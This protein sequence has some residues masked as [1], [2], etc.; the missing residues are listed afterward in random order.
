[1]KIFVSSTTKD[2]ADARKKVCEQIAGLDN[3]YVCMDCY[4]ASG[5]P[6]AE[7]DDSKVKECDAFVI[8]VAHYYGSCPP[9][10]ERSFTELEY[11]AAVASDKP[12]YA[13]LASE[14]FPRHLRENDATYATLEAF[15]QKLGEKHLPKY[16]DNPDQ[17]CAHVAAAVPRP[18]EQAGRITVPKLPQPYLA[19]PYPIQENFTGRVKERTML[20]DWVSGAD[21]RPMLSLVGMGGLGKSALTWF[22]LH[23]DLPQEKLTFSGIIWWSFYE[24]EASFESFLAHALLYASG[25]TIDPGQVPSDY[26][27]LSSLWCILRDS[28]FL[29][30]FDGAERLLRAYHALDAAYKGDDF[31]EQAGDKHLL[32]ADPRA[33]Q[34]L[35]WLATPGVKTRTLLTTRLHPR[36]LEALAGCRKKDLEHL[37]P[38][39]AVEF[40]RRQGIKGPRHAIVGACEP[41]DFLPLCI[42][43]L[44]GAIREDPERPG[45]IGVAEDWHPPANLKD[46]QRQHHILELSYDTMAKDRR[47]LLSRIAAMRGPV[48]YV[49]ATV[50]STYDDEDDLKAALLELVA[51]GLLFRREGQ[52]R[53]DLHPIV[54]QYAY[55]RLGDKAATHETLKDYFGT[56]PKP[57]KIETLDDLQPVIELFHHTI[58]AGGFEEALTIYQDRLEDALYFQ[59]GAYDVDISL[60]EAFFPEGT[61]KPPRLE[62][63][64]D[65]AWLLNAL[66]IACDKTGQSRKAAGLLERSNAI[67]ENR[68]NTAH[69]ARGLGNLV[70]SQMLL[71]ELEAAG[72]NLRRR[73]EID[74]KMDEKFDEAIGHQ[75]LGRLLTYTAA[76]DRADKE[77]ETALSMFAKQQ[78]EQCQGVVW[79]YRALRALMTDDPK[80]AVAALK[81]ARRFWELYAEHEAPIERDLVRILW[82]SG[83][84]RRGAG[85]ITGAET[86]LNEALSRCRRIR[87]VEFEADILLEMAR[88][89]WDKTRGKNTNLTEEAKS[90]T[91][92]ALEIADRCEYRLVQAD[93]HNFLAQMALAAGDEATAK[94]HAEIAKERAWCDG[95][96]HCYRKALDEAE[97]ILAKLPH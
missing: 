81:R 4:T 2:L 31:T 91:R 7:F 36:E 18:T 62:D 50:L 60:K 35:Q 88:L 49:T 29:I 11:E 65:Q 87:L 38:D 61:D 73:I 17:L 80:S 1:M 25:G 33:G 83:T 94:N 32:C 52:A 76:Y 37:E 56:V 96:P 20:T 14:D 68:G 95:P 44:S 15:R 57:E 42:R 51:R 85:D 40:M 8:I 41:Y 58:R 55:D 30:V 48:D 82:L 6:P 43:L 75:D 47:E 86:E 28:P 93:I 10:E 19:H 59:L 9:G 84:A 13:F 64:A 71:G 34:F 45:D 74:K 27:R 69:V 78:N 39:D 70:A 92:E 63:Q 24:S 22:W 77:L 16:F 53:Y 5:R 90:L 72:S 21:S 54:R 46:K 67:S 26:D 66:A 12:I 23:E 3:Q 79:S 89:Q 97:R